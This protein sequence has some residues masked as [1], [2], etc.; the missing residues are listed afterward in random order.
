MNHTAGT[1]TTRQLSCA[2]YDMFHLL[3][4]LLL[5]PYVAKSG[6][7][8]LW[9]NFFYFSFPSSPFKVHIEITVFLTCIVPLSNAIQHSRHWDIL[10]FCIICLFS[11]AVQK[12][13]SYYTTIYEC[14]SFVGMLLL[15]LLSVK[16]HALL[17]TGRKTNCFTKCQAK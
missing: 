14:T 17:F 3:Q 1:Q 2:L 11:A 9:P 8:I 10:Q 13:T 16:A 4:A 5:V 12:H 6:D 15:W 7:E